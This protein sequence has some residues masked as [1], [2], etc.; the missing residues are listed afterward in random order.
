MSSD[1][2]SDYVA[3][4]KSFIDTF[5]RYHRASPDENQHIFSHVTKQI[6]DPR[7]ISHK[8]EYLEGRKGLEPITV[9]EHKDLTVYKRIFHPGP[10]EWVTGADFVLEKMRKG[11]ALGITAIQVKRN[12]GRKSFDFAPREFRQ[13]SRF[14]QTFG[15]AYY[16]MIDETISPPGECFIRTNELRSLVG[17]S[18]ASTVQITNFDV[19]RFCRGS[20]LFYGEFYS[21]RRGAWSSQAIYDT[22]T[23][24][25][26]KMERRAVVDIMTK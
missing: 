26:A 4:A 6:S 17:Y 16:L 1:S 10:G 13:L 23:S 19:R 18:D 7:T 25:Y 11:T 5:A 9:I 14:E 2:P 3:D 15:S 22:I 20:D 12:H 21:C 8:T 24:M